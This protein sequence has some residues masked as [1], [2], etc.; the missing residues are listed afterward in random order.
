MGPFLEWNLAIWNLNSRFDCLEL[1]RNIMDLNKY[2]EDRYLILNIPINKI[3]KNQNCITKTLLKR[4]KQD[5][6]LS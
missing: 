6:S 4:A 1:H 2:R 5:Y 3:D